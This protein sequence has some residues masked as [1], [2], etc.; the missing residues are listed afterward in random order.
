MSAAD[1]VFHIRHTHEE[2]KVLAWCGSPLSNTEWAFE[3]VDHALYTLVREASQT[4]CND[5]RRKIEGVF[6]GY[7]RVLEDVRGQRG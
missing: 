3:N 2:K 4:P 1:G 6:D 5:C 7:P